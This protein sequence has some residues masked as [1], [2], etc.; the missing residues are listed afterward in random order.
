MATTINFPPS[1]T[2]GDTYTY[3]STTYEWDG[4]RWFPQGTD[5]TIYSES[6]ALSD[7]DTDLT[8]GT[9][10]LKFRLPFDMTPTDLRI[11][12]GTAPTGSTIIV[13]INKAGAT[14]INN[15]L[16]ID[17]S[18]KT[19]VTAAVPFDFGGTGHTDWYDDTEITV[20]IDQV[21]ST[22]KGAGLKLTLY[23]TKGAT[24]FEPL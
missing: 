9:A 12:V 20:D 14:T 7:E 22:I 21:G 6:Y 3:I 11:G 17:A 16:S 15:K 13:D 5:N 4:T 19:S 24:P 2:I 23:Y 10:K 8:T 18:E 1:P